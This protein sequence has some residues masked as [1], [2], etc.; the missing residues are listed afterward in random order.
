MN[1]SSSTEEDNGRIVKTYSH[2]VKQYLPDYMGL[3]FEKIGLD[4][5]ELLRDYAVVFR[6]GNK[7]HYYI[8]SKGGFTDGLLQAQAR[9]EVQLIT[10]EQLCK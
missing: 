1:V 4:E 7:Y 10:M 9:G 5:L 2:A 6:K 8:F 3:I